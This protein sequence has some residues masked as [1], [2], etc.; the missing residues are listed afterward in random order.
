MLGGD[1]LLCRKMLIIRS[2]G[3]LSVVLCGSQFI[4]VRRDST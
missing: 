2:G 4:V 3:N 1:V